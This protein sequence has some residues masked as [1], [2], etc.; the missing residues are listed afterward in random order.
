MNSDQFEKQPYLAHTCMYV[1]APDSLQS[2]C[3][4]RQ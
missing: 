4:K 2:V 1:Q 3:E